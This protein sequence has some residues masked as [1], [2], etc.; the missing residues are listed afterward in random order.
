VSTSDYVDFSNPLTVPNDSAPSVVPAPRF[1]AQA[2]PAPVLRAVRLTGRPDAAIPPRDRFAADRAAAPR[3][4]AANAHAATGPLAQRRAAADRERAE[5]AVRVAQRLQQL[6]AE[7][8][9]H[10]RARQA[11]HA[12][13]RAPRSQ[14]VKP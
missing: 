6:R 5:Q 11:A 12:P 14:G 2:R 8:A 13:P 10:E 7:V 4:A 9:S 3:T 1:L